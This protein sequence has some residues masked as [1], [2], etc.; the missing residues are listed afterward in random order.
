MASQAVYIIDKAHN[1]MQNFPSDVMNE[2]R[3]N[4]YNSTRSRQKSVI[5][6]TSSLSGASSKPP[7]LPSLARKS[8]LPAIEHEKKLRSIIGLCD[9]GRSLSE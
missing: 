1:S 6:R 5:S 7:R 9:G 8:A 3:A 2:H 4:P